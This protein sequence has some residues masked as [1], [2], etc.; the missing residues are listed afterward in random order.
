MDSCNY[1][2]N[3]VELWFQKEKYIMF[4]F[5]LSFPI[6]IM[7]ILLHPYNF[8]HIEFRKENYFILNTIICY[9]QIRPNVELYSG[10]EQS[11]FRLFFIS[12]FV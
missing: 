11:T 2:W 8:I 9:A 6:F 3:I 12:R 5:D 1:A 10:R 7:Y 4:S